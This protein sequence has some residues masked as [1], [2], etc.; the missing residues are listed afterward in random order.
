MI[1]YVFALDCHSGFSGW[2]DVA[3][4]AEYA[5]KGQIYK[6][7]IAAEPGQLERL[8]NY[9]QYF[10][11][12]LSPSFYQCSIEINCHQLWKNCNKIFTR[13]LRLRPFHYTK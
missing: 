6:Q 2:I 5:F 12:T 3:C 13:Y 10:L 9:E 7:R 8:H 11:N 4:Q 1:K